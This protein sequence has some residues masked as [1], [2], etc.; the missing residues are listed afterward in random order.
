MSLL[1]I[2]SGGTVTPC[3]CIL[4]CHP[5]SSPFSSCL[6]SPLNIPL[7]VLPHRWWHPAAMEHR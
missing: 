1:I 5:L 3:C 7:K 4:P 2:S 6:L